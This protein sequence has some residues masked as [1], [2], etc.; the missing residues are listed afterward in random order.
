MSFVVSQKIVHKLMKWQFLKTPEIRRNDKKFLNNH[1]LSLKKCGIFRKN[2]QK[3][4]YSIFWNFI[5]IFESSQVLHVENIELGRSNFYCI[6]SRLFYNYCDPP[7]WRLSKKYQ[8]SAYPSCLIVAEWLQTDVVK[9]FPFKA[10]IY[11]FQP[12]YKT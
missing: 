2:V 12:K 9:I 6:L 8:S 1:Y 3:I 7:L 11:S 5:N 4:F 10:Q